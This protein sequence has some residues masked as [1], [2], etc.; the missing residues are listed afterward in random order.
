[1][2][3]SDQLQSIV[4]S[5][6]GVVAASIM[7]F[8]GI[9]VET[10]HSATGSETAASIELTNAWVEFSNVLSQLK[11]AAQTLKT[12][13]ITEVS[14]STEKVVTVMRMITAEYFLVVGVLPTGNLGKARYV[15]RVGSP[16]LAQEL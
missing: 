10:A 1:M 7:G 15:M 8:D 14:V 4:K 6:D 16:A 2:A 3:L 9:A 12:G 5:V 11:L 13:G